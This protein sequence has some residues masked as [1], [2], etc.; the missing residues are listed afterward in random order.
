MNT[1]LMNS[2][3]NKTSDPHRLLLSLTD[4]VNFKKNVINMLLYQILAFTITGKMQKSH[5]KIINLKYQLRHEIKS[6]NYLI[7]HSL[8]QIS[9]IIFNISYK[10]MKKRLIIL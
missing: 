6:L 9:K 4:K 7:N 2:K 5:T 3:N 8:Y 10:N 1:I